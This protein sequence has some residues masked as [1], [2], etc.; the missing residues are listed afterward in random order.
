MRN[1]KFLRVWTPLVLTILFV[2]L[3]VVGGP[4]NAID[5]AIIQRLTAIREAHPAFTSA[6]IGLTFIGSAYCTLG[7]AAVVGAILAIRRKTVHAML[8]LSGVFGERLAMDGLKLLIGRPRPALDH[9]VTV[10]SMSFPSG[11]TAN[12]M[13]AYVL[14]ALLALPP[15]WRGPGV[16]AAIVLATA[17]GLTRPYLGVHWPTDVLGGWCLAGFA[18]W[19]TLRAER[20]LNASAR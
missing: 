4:H 18:I 11:H 3:A 20:S 16:V 19:C 14:L 13:T 12:S 15:R 8:L 2:V 9:P 6:M 10:S 1:E 7:S 5:V 17:I